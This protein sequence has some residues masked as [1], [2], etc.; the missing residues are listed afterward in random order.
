MN[1]SD[2]FGLTLMEA[3]VS[4]AILI[5]LYCLKELRECKRLY[6]QADKL[7]YGIAIAIQAKHPEITLINESVTGDGDHALSRR[8]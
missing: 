7:T 8:V 6:H 1:I 4:L 3:A 2:Y 5:G